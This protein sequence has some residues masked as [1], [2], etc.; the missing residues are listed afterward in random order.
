MGQY[1][2]KEALFKINNVSK[3]THWIKQLK[4]TELFEY[5]NY[6]SVPWWSSPRIWNLTKPSSIQ[7][8]SNWGCCGHSDGVTVF[9]PELC[10][11][12]EH[13]QF[14]LIHIIG[15][16]VVSTCVLTGIE[17]ETDVGRT[18]WIA[19]NEVR[20]SADWAKYLT[21]RFIGFVTRETFILFSI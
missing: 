1:K 8:F 19:P 11:H 2:T 4:Q 20:F 9:C 10:L 7:T 18:C 3:H 12:F 21:N 6:E 14:H 13:S 17:I 16:L 15:S 5:I